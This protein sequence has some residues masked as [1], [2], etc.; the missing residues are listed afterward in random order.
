MLKKMDVW[1]TFAQLNVFGELC[2]IFW[3]Y[4]LKMCIKSIQVDALGSCLD[5]EGTDARF[6][7]FVTHSKQD[8]SIMQA[9][10]FFCWR[11]QEGQDLFIF[12]GF[13]YRVTKSF[14]TYF[15]NLY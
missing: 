11:E 8:T 1:P 4:L 7:T 15:K 2:T 10:F 3:T 12:L 6:G 14:N 5:E 13:F 9:L